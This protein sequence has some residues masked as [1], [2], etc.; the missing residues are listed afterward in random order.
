MFESVFYEAAQR[1]AQ[2]AALDT[3]KAT[4][5]YQQA[6]RDNPTMIDTTYVDFSNPESVARMQTP[7]LNPFG[8]YNPYANPNLVNQNAGYNPALYMSNS[9]GGGSWYGGNWGGD[10]T[11]FM[12]PSPDDK[13]IPIGEVVHGTPKPMERKMGYM[14]KLRAEPTVVVYRGSQEP[15]P[16]KKEDDNPHY[17][18]VPR[19][20]YHP[21]MTPYTIE[22]LDPDRGQLRMIPDTPLVWTARDDEELDRLV[23]DLAVYDK[24]MAHVA[25]NVPHIDGCTREDW[26]YIKRYFQ[27][28]IQDFRS[29]ELMNQGLD[30]RAK[31]RHRRLPATIIIDGDSMP[32][33]SQPVP[34]PTK[35][36]TLSGEVEYDYDRGRDML[37]EEEWDIFVDR[38]YGE[39]LQ[40][41]EKIKARDLMQL[42]QH[43]SQPQTPKKEEDDKYNPYDPISVKLHNM[44]NSQ[45][46][47]MTNMEFFKHVFRHR[48]TPEQFD[49]WWYGTQSN[50]TRYGNKPIDQAQAQQMWAKQMSEA[51]YNI[52]MQF[53]PYDKDAVRSWMN[54]RA[55]EAFNNYTKGTV[56]KDMSLADFMRN[57]R[58]LDTRNHELNLEAQRMA[59][60]QAMWNNMSHD[61]FNR[62]LYQYMNSPQYANTNP[63]YTPQYGTIDPRFGM[64]SQYIDLTNNPMA[65]QK[66]QQF[67]Q[68]CHTTTGTV[69]LSPI[70]R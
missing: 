53:R 23:E 50:A 16:T 36:I 63:Y 61:T 70:Y 20:K 6:R 57:L 29:K 41:A 2:Q 51:N 44:R 10:D 3:Y 5:E 11:R 22:E 64:P 40:G 1:R 52:L 35:R 47:Y 37:T 24:A 60:Q 31:Y 33:Y 45:K 39:M 9:Y 14:E 65:Q 26:T 48:L 28:R 56:T 32:D 8:T 38:A 68:H 7:I 13:L 4:L 18:V 67:L 49:N 12:N 43:L 66:K 17:Q 25:F 34:I 55:L 21:P 27:D 30:Y 58:Y 62:S 59:N 46:A 15:L 54:Q 19:P 42:N 69:P